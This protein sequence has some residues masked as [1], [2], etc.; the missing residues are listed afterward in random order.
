[1]WHDLAEDILHN[2]DGGQAVM[3]V[4]V[5]DIETDIV[6]ALLAV[7]FGSMPRGAEGIKA[8]G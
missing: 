7:P 1:M 2:V 4:V 8:I 6:K 5:E 3:I